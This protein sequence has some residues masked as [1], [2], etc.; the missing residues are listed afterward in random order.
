MNVT[1]QF[2]TGKFH[3][4]QDRRSKFI[5]TD[6]S[7]P[8]TIALYSIAAIATL[9]LLTWRRYSTPAGKVCT[10]YFVESVVQTI[11][12]NF[13][14]FTLNRNGSVQETFGTLS[15]ALSREVSEPCPS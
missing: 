8:F 5:V 2:F 1:F 13:H 15:K 14:H 7:L 6:K 12:P 4:F 3:G 9:L 10:K 11:T